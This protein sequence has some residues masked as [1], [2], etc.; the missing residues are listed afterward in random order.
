MGNRFS[1]IIFLVSLYSI[2]IY[3]GTDCVSNLV[4]T[5]P[6]DCMI[7]DFLNL[8]CLQIIAIYF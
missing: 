2:E 4:I 8:I 3:S 5:I 6:A 1:K 7:A